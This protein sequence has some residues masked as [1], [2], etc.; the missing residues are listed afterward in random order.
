[1]KNK[2]LSISAMVAFS[3]A[4]SN[5]RNNSDHV[6][7]ELEMLMPKSSLFVDTIDNK[8]TQLFTIK[9]GDGLVASITNYGGRVV[10]L[11]VP[12]RSGNP[13]DVVIGMNSPQGYAEA[14]EPYL[15]ALIGRVGNRIAK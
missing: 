15:G 3:A 5:P 2:I 4:C 11:I 7:T 6:H 12:D 8:P 1:M 13:T 14:S 10:G 9:K